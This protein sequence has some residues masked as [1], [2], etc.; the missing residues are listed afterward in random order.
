MTLHKLR[1]WVKWRFFANSYL[2]S[3]RRVPTIMS[4]DRFATI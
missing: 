2:C 3:L 4:R 1:L